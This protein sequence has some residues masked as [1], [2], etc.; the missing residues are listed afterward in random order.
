[1]KLNSFW[2][3][4]SFG[5]NPQS[6]LIIRW[7]CLYFKSYDF[8][9]VNI[10]KCNANISSCCINPKFLTYYFLICLPLY[11]YVEI[12]RT[13]RHDLSLF[14]YIKNSRSNIKKTCKHLFLFLATHLHYVGPW[15]LLWVQGF[16]TSDAQWWP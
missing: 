5:S 4:I 15:I 3:I 2:K 7:N 16:L 14:F 1:M 11:R 6:F 9:E 8:T 12:S 13:F 10:S